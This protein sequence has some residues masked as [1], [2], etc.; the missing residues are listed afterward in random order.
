MTVKCKKCGREYPDDWK[1]RVCFFC[2]VTGQEA[3]IEIQEI[4]ECPE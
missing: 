4:L 3:G 2:W 1:G